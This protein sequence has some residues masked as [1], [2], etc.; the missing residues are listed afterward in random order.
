M[1]ITTTNLQFYWLVAHRRHQVPLH[2]PHLFCRP[3]MWLLQV[4]IGKFSHP[5][6]ICIISWVLH[7]EM[8]TLTCLEA[9]RLEWGR[10]WCPTQGDFPFWLFLSTKNSLELKNPMY[11]LYTAAALS[12]QWQLQQQYLLQCLLPVLLK[13]RYAS[14]SD[15]HLKFFL[16]FL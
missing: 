2:H 11:K 8:R 3:L 13:P 14:A 10:T 4:F 9:W 12:S 1:S 5:L 16:K 15:Y 7:Q 6:V